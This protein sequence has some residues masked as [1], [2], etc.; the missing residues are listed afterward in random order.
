MEPFKLREEILKE[1]SLAQCKKIVQWVGSD[2]KHFDELFNLFLNDEYRVTQ[3]AGWPLSKCV[4]QHPG[5][6]KKNFGKLITN[7]QRSHLH[8]AIKRN[9]IR[10]LQHV[11]IPKKYQG[12]VMNTCFSYVETPKEA[13]AIKAFSLTVLGKLAK[14][15]PEILPELKLLIEERWDYETAAFRSRAKKI[16]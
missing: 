14:N 11:D 6:I 2:Q 13:V 10:L 4:E 15:Y 7:L 9:T 8:D 16:L 5:F 12:Q 3:R 1:H